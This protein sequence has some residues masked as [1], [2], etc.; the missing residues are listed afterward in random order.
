LD[1]VGEMKDHLVH[2][3][4][5]ADGPGN[6]SDGGVRGHPRD[7]VPGVE[8]AELVVTDAAGHHRDV[9][10]I[11]AR[12][13]CVERRGRVADHELV[14]DV[15]VPKMTEE[16]LVGW[17]G[18]VRGL[19]VTHLGRPFSVMESHARTPGATT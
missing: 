14:A 4:I 5:S 2:Q 1:R 9:V 15:L 18:R 10:D 19:R 17:K 6:W 7:E 11:G 13:H 12:H 3:P 16:L 8:L